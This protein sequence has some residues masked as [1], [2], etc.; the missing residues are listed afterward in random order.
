MGSLQ[1]EDVCLWEEG[2]A[3]QEDKAL[4]EHGPPQRQLAALRDWEM[5]SH[6]CEMGSPRRMQRLPAAMSHP[7]RTRISN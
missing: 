6:G 2:A 3:N 7:N 1:G 5:A 4:G